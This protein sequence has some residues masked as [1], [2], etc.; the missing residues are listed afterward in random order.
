M[1]ALIV[2]LCFLALCRVAPVGAQLLGGSTRPRTLAGDVTGDM[3]A[4]AGT[5]DSHDHTG[6][7]VS[8]LDAGDTT[9]GA[10]GTARIPGGTDVSTFA[11]DADN[12]GGGEP[13]TGAGWKIE[14]GSGDINALYDATGNDLEFSGAAGGYTFDAAIHGTADNATTA[15]TANAGDS[16]TAFFSTGTLEDALLPSTI[17]RDSE[18]P[19]Y[20][21][22]PG[23]PLLAL[24][25]LGNLCAGNESTRRNSG[26]TANECFTP[27]TAETG[28]I[29][30]VWGCST[31]NCNALTAAAGDSFSAASAD[32]SATCKV[33]TSVPGSCNTGE[34]FIDSDAAFGS[35]V[36]WCLGGAYAATE[37][38]FGLAIDGSEWATTVTL[39]TNRAPDLARSEEH[40]S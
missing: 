36:L 17:T 3:E 22:D 29:T 20:E 39:A 7:T 10:F 31:G 8:A 27:L 38:P 6:S 25:D 2:A 13:A 35:Q 40:T 23:V 4:N 30:D 32:T 18:V 15:A 37:N 24:S 14:G 1:K 19:T 5:N 34:C 33:G 21:T 16:A 28:D 9:T 26:D 11:A 12:T